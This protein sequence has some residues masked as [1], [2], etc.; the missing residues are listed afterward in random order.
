MNNERILTLIE[1]LVLIAVGTVIGFIGAALFPNRDLVRIFCMAI[2]FVICFTPRKIARS[3]ALHLY[4]K[5]E[6]HGKEQN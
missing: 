1:L 6:H 5:K 2:A 4:T 3:I